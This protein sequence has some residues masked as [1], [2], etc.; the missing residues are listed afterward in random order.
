MEQLIETL[1]EIFKE[2]DE[3][4]IE[5]QVKWA[6][7]RF[8]ALHEWLKSEE[9]KNWYKNSTKETYW[10]L[11]NAFYEKK[12]SLC[13]GK[14]WYNKIYGTS[15]KGCEEIARKNAINTIE[16][17]NNSIVKKLIKAEVTGVISKEYIW[18]ND[19]FNGVFSVNTNKGIKTINIETIYAGG[20]N[21]QC[22]HM[23]TLIKIK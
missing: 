4:F 18:T 19:G 21:I 1:K 2:R 11:N 7:D 16:A 20:Y 12:F 22:L 9:A 13:G 14:T 10:Q 5:D 17:R 3:K 23:R 6:V 8:N 15:T